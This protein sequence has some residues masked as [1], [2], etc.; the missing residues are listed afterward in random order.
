MGGLR[1]GNS[2]GELE[3]RANFQYYE[4]VMESHANYNF[5]TEFKTSKVRLQAKL[6][7][8][9]LTTNSVIEALERQG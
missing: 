6:L 4:L 2:V 3:E 7:W 8:L 1:P 9:F 5:H